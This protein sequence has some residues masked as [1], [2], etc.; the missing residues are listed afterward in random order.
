M[1]ELPGF[2]DGLDVK[3]ACVCGGGWRTWCEDR[4]ESVSEPTLTPGPLA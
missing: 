3:C 4:R 1:V 2:A